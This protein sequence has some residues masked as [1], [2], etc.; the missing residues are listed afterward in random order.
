MCIPILLLEKYIRDSIFTVLSGTMSV[1]GWVPGDLD[2]WVN[3]D[4][5]KHT[6]MCTHTHT[7]VHTN[8]LRIMDIGW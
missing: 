5:L 4:T 1:A 7:H 6:R 2:Y 8:S 3:S